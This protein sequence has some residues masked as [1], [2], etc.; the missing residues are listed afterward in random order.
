MHR[1]L[2]LGQHTG[3]KRLKATC[4]RHPDSGLRRRK[5]RINR[6][7]ARQALSMSRWSKRPVTPEVAGSSPVAPVKSP[8]K[9]HDVLSIQTPD[10]GRLHKRAF[11]TALNFQNGSKTRPRGHDFKPFFAAARLTAKAAGDYTKWPEVKPATG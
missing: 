2:L 11:E 10:L 7:T 8:A 4:C 6:V 5:G 9:R 1:R 3:S